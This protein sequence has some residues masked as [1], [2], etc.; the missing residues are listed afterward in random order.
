M[1]IAEL[2]EAGTLGMAQQAALEADRTHFVARSPAGRM[3]NSP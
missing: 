1:R 3:K 2:H